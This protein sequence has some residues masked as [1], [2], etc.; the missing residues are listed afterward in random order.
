MYADLDYSTELCH[1]GI[2]GQKWGVRR[3]QNE[4]GSLTPK[5]QKHYAVKEAKSAYK[6]AKKDLKKTI[7]YEKNNLSVS[8]RLFGAAGINNIQRYRASKDNIMNKE[9]NRVKA[10][11]DLAKAK[12]GEKAEMRAYRKEMSK[13]GIRESYND[14]NSD[15]RSTKLFNKI[16][17]E[18]GRE[19]AQKVERKV[20]NVAIAQLAGAVT[21][22]VGS[23]FVAAYLE[24]K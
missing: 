22:S 12:H 13:T 11:A 15:Y 16:Q 17:E 6:A 23:A 19:Y 14:R 1:H 4:D 5:G 8:Q 2:L 24:N 21:L 10:K 20:Q 18:K 3:F 7:K 9:L